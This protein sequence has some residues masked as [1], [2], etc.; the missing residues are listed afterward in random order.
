MG[1]RWCA[2]PSQL[3]SKHPLTNLITLLHNSWLTAL[4]LSDRRAL[5]LCFSLLRG[6]Y[7]SNQRDLW[8]WHRPYNRKRRCVG[9]TAN[10][11]KA[12]SEG[13]S[14]YGSG[15]QYGS[16]CRIAFQSTKDGF[17]T[18]TLLRDFFKFFCITSKNKCIDVTEVNSCN[19]FLKFESIN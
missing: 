14:F 8:R 6:W 12:D 5:V 10:V 11:R 9:E 15:L 3:R 17:K 13:I 16:H 18:S 1:T 19:A 4:P 7:S 2:R